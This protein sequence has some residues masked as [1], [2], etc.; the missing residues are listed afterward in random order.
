MDA[1]DALDRAMLKAF[2][3][4]PAYAKEI[5]SLKAWL[6]RF[7]HNVCMDSHRE[8]ARRE[9][10]FESIEAADNA[11]ATTETDIGSP[12]SA[13]VRREQRARLLRA[14]QHLPFRLR[15]PFVLR[16]LHGFEYAEI[17]ARLGLTPSNV[18]K[19]IQHAREQLRETLNKSSGDRG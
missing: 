16:F 14:L 17:A 12:E 15:E 1:E 10:P 4:L 13:F 6:A 2:E 8:R 3:K 11:I 7:T 18:R 5:D 9:L 19:R